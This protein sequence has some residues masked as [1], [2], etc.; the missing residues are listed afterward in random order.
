MAQKPHAIEGLKVNWDF[1]KTHLAKHVVRDICNKGA[2]RNYS[3]HPNES[4]HGPLKEAYQLRSNGKDI[5]GQV[6]H[7]SIAVLQ[8]TINKDDKNIG[9]AC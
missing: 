3:T 8:I 9:S 4:M 2:A 5:A 7:Y 6:R 1:P